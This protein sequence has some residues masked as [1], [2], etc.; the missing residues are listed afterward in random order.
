[1]VLEN[2]VQPFLDWFLGDLS[3]W[4]AGPM[5]LVTLLVLALGS[6]VIGLLVSIILYGP[7]KG[8]ERVYTVVRNGL[9]EMFYWSPRRVSAIARLAVQESLRK[10]VLVAIVVFVILLLFAGWFLQSENDPAKIYFSFVLTATAYMGVFIGLLL[11]VFSLPDDFKSKTIYTIVTKPV[12]AGDI[13]LGRILGFTF[14]GTMLLLIMGAI[15]YIFVWRSLDH[16]H[17]LDETVMQDIRDAD[18]EVVATIPQLTTLDNGHRHEI[19]VNDDGGIV[20]AFAQ[21]HEHEVLQD[22]DKLTVSPP[23]S[24][25]RARVPKYGSIVFRDPNGN[26]VARGVS[27]GKEW[28][29]R[30]FIQGGSQSAAIWTFDNVDES[31]LIENKRD[32]T[33]YLPLELIVRVFR[34][35]KADIETPVQGS[36]QLRN[37]ETDLKSRIEF[38]SA[39]DDYI[40]SQY[41]PRK[42]TDSDNNPIDLLKDLVSKEG[43]LEVVVQCVDRAQYFGF[44]MADC[45][46]RRP[47]ASPLVNFAKAMVSIWVQMVIVIAIAVAASALLTGPIALMLTS[48][49]VLLGYYKE[50][51][52]SV[53]R[54]AA[55]GGGPLEALVRLVTH[56]NLTSPF[57]NEKDRFE[58]QL[59]KNV[60]NVIGVFM[61]GV[62]NILPDFTQFNGS[63]YVAS[64]FDIPW[65][66]IVQQLLTCLAFVIGSTVIGYFFL[67]NREVAR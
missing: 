37:P 22:G 7:L 16:S 35:Y 59:L 6:V 18:G 67:R 10:R 14:V 48:S 54:G 36:I 26:P 45:F 9:A 49:L 53:A 29:Y 39:R 62:A 4:G 64:G 41:F 17:Q 25:M 33:E 43:Q 44:A 57:P 58:I 47:D 1:M 31:L 3:N 42:L 8:G 2:P 55:E 23:L 40:D 61:Q 50:F 30:S 38:F 20:A 63:S 24:T 15:S 65:P 13:V 56:M 46:I 51:F 5:F 12:R 11:S 60:D 52:V 32:E 66:L 21:G 27:V 34:T 28:K 19:R